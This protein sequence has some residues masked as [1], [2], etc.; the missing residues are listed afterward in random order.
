M[1]YIRLFFSKSLSINLN[2][3]LDK[4]QSHYLTKVVR[5]KLMVKLFL[6]LIKAGSGRQK[7]KNIKRFSRILKLLQ[8][9]RQKKMKK[10]YG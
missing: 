5:L 3:K 7:W 6:Y 10:K 8:K 9:L 4:S 1:N 2:S